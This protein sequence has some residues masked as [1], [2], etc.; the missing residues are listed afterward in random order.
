MFSTVVELLERV[1]ELPMLIAIRR[2]LAV[3][4]PL[5]IAGAAALLVLNLPAPWFHDAL[6]SVAGNHWR[7]LC[8]LIH[9]G[10]FSIAALAVL[11]STSASYAKN[12]NSDQFRVN[13]KVT[14]A[15]CLSCYFVM[16]VPIDTPIPQG[17]FSLGSGGFPIAIA[18][19]V[20]GTPLFLFLLRHLQFANFFQTGV[21]DPDFHD[22][23]AA[24][25][26]ATTMILL[27][28]LVRV[29]LGYMGQNNP[30]LLVQ[31][32]FS[33]P[34]MG[35]GPD[36]LIG[37][38]YILMSQILWFFGIHGPNLLFMVERNILTPASMENISN[39][40]AGLAPQHIF[41]KPF[42]DA[43]A[44]IGGSGATLALILAILLRSKEVGTRRLAI[45]AFVPALFNVNEI[46]LLGLPLVL[47]PAYA[48]PFFLA[49]IIQAL[50]AW[51]A[52]ALGLVPM[53]VANIHWTA[54]PVLG[55]YAATGSTAGAVLQLVCLGVGVL[56]YLPFVNLAN[57]IHLRRFKK[58][59]DALN[60]AASEI[61][62]GFGRQ[63]CIDLS[64]PPGHLA[65]TLAL[66]LKNALKTGDQIHLEY[67]PQV[68][69]DR[70]RI[71]GA[72]ALLRWRHPLHGPIPASLAVALAEDANLMD[73]LTR[74]ILLKACNQQMV[75]VRKGF[76]DI[77]LSV[78]ISA[79]QFNNKELIYLI[80]DVLEQSGLP[81]HL[82]Q[83]EITETMALSPDMQSVEI[84]GRLREMGL[85]IAIDDFGM[86]HTSLRYFTQ[87]AVETVKIDRSLTQD[88]A[89]GVNNHIISSIV[90]LCEALG[91]Q[92]VVE[93][94]EI[95]AQL[96][97]FRAHRCNLYQGYLFSRP[98]SPENYLKY[99]E[100]EGFQI[101]APVEDA[102]N[103]PVPPPLI[104][105][106]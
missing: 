49:P 55:G 36:L 76:T 62:S 58:S 34:F 21:S 6:T 95:Q 16:A 4:L 53:T 87:F 99:C 98:L 54:P 74:M 72:E 77:K 59:L 57:A 30:H 94:V 17:F 79:T 26:A 101:E 67:Q 8:E 103:R 41:T 28:G 48:I 32:L 11:I 71:I 65:R 75:L 73:R 46:M 66:D 47:N 81:P 10:S 50:V 25:P 69:V 20:I 51:A 104:H 15:V 88:S 22:A 23:L 56:I 3:V 63:K 44:N 14:S 37:V 31:N 12:Y 78:N 18:I 102:E 106:Q 70:H 85:L 84:L 105:L 52:T 38:A 43:F 60:R 9:R 40:A 13:S 29:F 24:V 64:G 2:G 39:L 93:G 90:H 97:R 68:D 19:A 5:I 61:T 89:N 33:A 82:L 35:N 86:G 27:F 45:V 96:D 91:V 80:E 92:I 7:T 100:G 83:L 1:A 42:V